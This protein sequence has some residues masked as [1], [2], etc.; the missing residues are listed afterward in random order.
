MAILAA[1]FSRSSFRS[2]GSPLGFVALVN[3]R[4]GASRPLSRRVAAGS[5]D[6]G[7]AGPRPARGLKALLVRKPA[8]LD[9]AA[10]DPEAPVFPPVFFDRT[11][12]EDRQEPAQAFREKPKERMFS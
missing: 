6:L 10:P 9:P 1:R 2:T 7:K 3:R 4:P 8:P 12:R 5:A 11:R